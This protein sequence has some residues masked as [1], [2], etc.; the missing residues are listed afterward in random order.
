ML[1]PTASAISQAD[2][3]RLFFESVEYC[4]CG[5]VQTEVKFYKELPESARTQSEL[6]RRIDKV[7]REKE[8]REA[9]MAQEKFLNDQLSLEGPPQKQPRGHAAKEQKKGTKP[10][11]KKTQNNENDVHGGGMGGKKLTISLSNNSTIK[12]AN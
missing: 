2:L 4:Q 5:D 6:R 12:I 3:E 7:L 10:E 1:E 8:I 11:P 9:H